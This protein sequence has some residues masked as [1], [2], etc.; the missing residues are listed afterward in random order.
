MRNKQLYYKVISTSPIAFVLTVFDFLFEYFFRKLA[1]YRNERLRFA[2]VELEE[3]LKESTKA[4]SKT[5]S[6]FGTELDA[7]ANSLLNTA[8]SVFELEGGGQVNYTL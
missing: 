2:E 5:Q 1:A 8:W 3:S 4:M 7:W 6:A